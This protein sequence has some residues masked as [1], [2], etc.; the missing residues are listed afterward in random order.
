MFKQIKV[1]HIS[2]EIFDQIKE[3]ILEGKLKPGQKL[4]TERE[5][6]SQLGVSRVPIREALKLLANMGFI[7]TTQGGGSYVKPLLATRVR[8]PLNH[9][10]KDDVEKIFDLLEVR[11]ELETWSAYRAAEKATEDDIV[12]LGRMI[13]ET[14]AL[15]KEG[16]KPPASLDADFHLAIAHCSHNTIRAHLTFTIYDIFSEYFNY[17]IENICFSKKYQESIYDQHYHIYDAI[18]RHDAEAARG[19]VTDHLAFVGEELRKQTGGNH[20]EVS[21]RPAKSRSQ[22]KL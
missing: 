8:D 7:E 11:K 12:S 9:I 5:L 22:N 17:L 20:K 10:I 1:R 18:R 2:E 21:E 13:E 3:A 15:F 19:A 4:P 6:M 16:K 14:K